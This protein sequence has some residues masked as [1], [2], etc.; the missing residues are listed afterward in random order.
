MSVRISLVSV[1]VLGLQSV[2]RNFLLNCVKLV[3]KLVASAKV[4]LRLYFICSTIQNF[5]QYMFMAN[6]MY[7]FLTCEH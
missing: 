3:R 7:F 4:T 2:H 6:N 1:K 5:Y